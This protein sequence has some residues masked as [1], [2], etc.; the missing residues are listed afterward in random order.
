MKIPFILRKCKYC[1]P[2]IVAH[3]NMVP[4][5]QQIFGGEGEIKPKSTV[6]NKNTANN[7]PK[8]LKVL[9]K[10]KVPSQISLKINKSTVYNKSTIKNFFK[11]K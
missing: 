10:I 7:V 11:N 1:C 8:I 9:F 5:N 3:F 2:H 4:Q 6:H